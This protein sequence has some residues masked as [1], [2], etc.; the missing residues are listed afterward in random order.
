MTHKQ[1]TLLLGLIKLAFFYISK[2]STRII[3]LNF[4]IKK[5]KIKEELVEKSL[6]RDLI[7]YLKTGSGKTYI[8]VKVIKEL[9]EQE[10]D[11]RKIIFLANTVPLVM[12]QCKFLKKFIS[13]SIEE[14]YGEKRLDGKLLDAWDKEIWARELEKNQILVMSP[15][16][17]VDMLN[18]SFICVNSIKMIV[19]DE[20][21]HATGKHPY[22][23]VLDKLKDTVHRDIKILGLT[24]SIVQNK[25]TSQNFKNLMRALEK[26]FEYAKKNLLFYTN[27]IESFYN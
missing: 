7:V 4:N 15:A 25:C 21:H 2:Y 18:H 12:Q 19:F 1:R 9:V 13:A 5:N 16:I 24:A 27:C 6:S 14:Y 10:N 17:L 11:T 8:A 3:Y 23:Q 22:S 26:K 20:C